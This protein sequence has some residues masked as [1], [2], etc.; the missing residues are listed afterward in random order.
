[1]AKKKTRKK[2]TAAKIYGP[3]SRLYGRLSFATLRAA[4]A[5]CAKNPDA[6]FA[7]NKRPSGRVVVK[8]TF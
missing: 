1:M 5:W 7:I 6:W 4:A 2:K 3:T 8:R